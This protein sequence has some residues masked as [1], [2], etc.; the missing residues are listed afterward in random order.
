MT[1]ELTAKK[2]YYSARTKVNELRR[3]WMNEYPETVD[4]SCYNLVM[5]LIDS[6]ETA[7][8]LAGDVTE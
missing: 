8:R 7:A 5:H 4:Q 3:L 6:L 1:E 2:A